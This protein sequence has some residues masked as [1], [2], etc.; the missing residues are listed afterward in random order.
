MCRRIGEYISL[1]LFYFVNLTSRCP[2]ILCMM[3]LFVRSEI[4]CPYCFISGQKQCVI[5]CTFC[6]SSVFNVLCVFLL[7]VSFFASVRNCFWLLPLLQVRD[8]YFITSASP[9]ETDRHRPMLLRGSWSRFCFFSFSFRF[10]DAV[11]LCFI[12]FSWVASD[13]AAFLI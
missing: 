13:R 10:T 11:F 2:L 3:F 1:E 12:I 5:Y 9:F 7:I 8:N 4:V 6:F